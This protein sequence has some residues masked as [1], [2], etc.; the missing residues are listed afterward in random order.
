[1]STDPW[2][3][4]SD[5]L[6]EALHLLEVRGAFYCR[7]EFTTPFGLEL[8]PYEGYLWFHVITRGSCWLEAPGAQPRRLA[9][10][11]L[12]LV[13]HGQGHRLRSEPDAATPSIFALE[14]EQLG[15]RYEILR[16]G[17]GGERVDMVCGAVRFDHPAAGRLL[18]LL[19][20]ILTVDPAS[21]P[22]RLEWLRSTLRLMEL[23]ADG[24]RPGGE[25]VITRLSD[26]LVVQALR[27]WL[28]SDPAARSG[29]L[30][31]LQ[32]PLIGRAISLVH[33]EPGREWTVASLA[34]QV[35]MSR[36]AFAAR[37]TEL[38]GEPAMSYVT[39]WRMHLAATALRDEGATVAELASRFGY[40]SEAAF[41][42]AFKRVVGSPPGAVR[43][44]RPV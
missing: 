19:P 28:E 14:R 33:R 36:S 21:S 10:S 11:E 8:P 39:R 42:R 31:A 29:W 17:G 13:P 30:G 35:P 40:R 24:L 15:E 12:A 6:G 41:A 34:D 1:M 43:R 27:A 5:P 9:A 37:F 16:H 2:P 4:T 38:V 22:T 44:T 23:E 7:S 25:T 3:S 18:A 26:V 20:Q 32:D